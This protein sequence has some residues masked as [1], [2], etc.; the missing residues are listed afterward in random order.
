MSCPGFSASLDVDV[1]VDLKTIRQTLH[2]KHKTPHKQQRRKRPPPPKKK[3]SYTL[4]TLTILEE[5]MG[6]GY[7]EK[8]VTRSESHRH[9]LVLSGESLA[10]CRSHPNDRTCLML[11][12]VNCQARTV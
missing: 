10:D 9:I 8:E 11:A 2:A 6:Q 5:M 12:V 7:S 1:L 3:I 4:Q